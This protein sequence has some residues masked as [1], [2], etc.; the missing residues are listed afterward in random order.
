MKSLTSAKTSIHRKLH[1]CSSGFGETSL[2]DSNPRTSMA[3]NLHIKRAYEP[4]TA[5]DGERYLVDRLWPRGVKK[6]ALALTAWLKEA[7]PSQKLRKW[8]GHDPARWK[9]FCVRYR[10]ELQSHPGILE[11]LREA[12]DRGAVTLVYSTRD[13]AHNQAVALRDYLL[14]TTPSLRKVANRKRKL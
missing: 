11:L 5:Q 4:W 8:F 13:E 12:L 9:E 6:E 14:E 3:I 7:A 1:N 10:T 2:P